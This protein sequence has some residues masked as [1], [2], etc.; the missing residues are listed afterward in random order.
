MKEKS[1][2]KISIFC[3]DE[4]LTHLKLMVKLS[5]TWS[6]V[7]GQMIT[8]NQKVFN[9]AWKVFIKAHNMFFIMLLLVGDYMVPV[10][11]NKLFIKYILWLHVKSFIPARRDSSFVVRWFP[12]A[13]T[14]FSASARLSRMK[15]TLTHPYK[16]KL[17]ENA[18][19]L[20]KSCGKLSH[21]SR[22]KS[23]SAT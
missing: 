13:G 9:T 20:N 18:K 19:N 16:R 2:E 21:L 14:K 7:K 22:M 6:T 23:D 11:W 15:R 17:K 8:T 4:V 1:S 10:G 12:F 5:R 3:R